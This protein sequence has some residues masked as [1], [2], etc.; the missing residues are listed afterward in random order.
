[1]ILERVQKLKE[2]FNS[3]Y[4][5]IIREI[6]C[7]NKNLNAIFLTSVI[8]EDFFIN[9]ILSPILDYGA[10]L[11]EKGNLNDVSLD[12]LINKA[13]RI[14]DIVEV[15]TDEKI[16]QSLSSYKVLLFIEDEEKALAIN[17]VDYPRRN[18]NEPPTSAV[19]KGPREGFVEDYRYN[20]AMLRRRFSADALSI[21]H[22]KIG[23]YSQTDI[24]IAYIKEIASDKLVKKIKKKLEKIDID[25]IVD[26]Y[27][28]INFLQEKKRTIFKQ[29]GNYE[30]PDII[31]SKILEGRVAIIVNNTPIVLTVPFIFLEDLQNSNDYYR[32]S[33]FSTYVR[34]IRLMGILIGVILPGLYVTMR[35]Y[36]YSVMPINFLMTIGNSSETIPFTPFIE[37]VFILI[38]FEIL[39]EVS[40][41]LP[42]Y[43]GMATSI[44]G[45][46]ILGETGVS[47]GLISSPAVMIIALSVI[48]VYTV[49][50]QVDQLSL[51]R[52]AFLIIGPALG[53][54][55]IIA[56][57][58]FIIAYMNTINSYYSA[59]LAPFSPYIKND[60][61]D[62]I[63]KVSTDNM[64]TRPESFLN[65]NKVRLKNEEND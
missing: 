62:T 41:R 49:P 5:I 34:A 44:V 35:L 1:M 13:L 28:I 58:V 6:V 2:E 18:P 40:L 64:K 8:D 50:D 51:L 63:L 29:I 16:K 3:S 9:G 10:L 19:M 37:I 30:K 53:M 65:K 12:I 27:Y 31:A 23:R 11:T 42:R 59:Y 57:G 43:L 48:S 56:S 54:F 7:G 47:A 61:K 15:D 26:S 46:L 60:M 45:A 22:L 24:A 32:S 55:A 36:H 17:I 21:D 52:A 25:G 38:L 4:D 20:I 14:M 39:Y 33:Y